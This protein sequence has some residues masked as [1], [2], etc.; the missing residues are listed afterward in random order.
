MF[1]YLMLSAQLVLLSTENTTRVKKHLINKII[2][3]KV[4]LWQ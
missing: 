2:G 4:I 1:I 3:S